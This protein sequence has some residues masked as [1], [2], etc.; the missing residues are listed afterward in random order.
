MTIITSIISVI[1]GL[2]GS[3]GGSEGVSKMW[4][5][6]GVPLLLVS[7]A[8]LVLNNWW[9]LTIGLLGVVF[10]IGYGQISINDPVPSKLGKFFYDKFNGNL[11]LSEMATRGTLGLLQGL[12][13]LC[14]P[15]IKGNWQMYFMISIGIFLVNVIFGGEA[16]IKKEG[17][18]TF[19]GKKLLWEEFWIYFF[20]ALLTCILIF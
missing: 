7:I 14:I 20:L 1:T 15:I 6:L 9:V 19:L 11:R 8:L 17:M 18:F 4:R 3:L 5:R 16:I 13:L 2:L 10:S 12:C